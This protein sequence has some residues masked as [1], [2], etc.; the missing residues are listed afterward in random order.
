VS[1]AGKDPNKRHRHDVGQVSHGP[2]SQE[3]LMRGI[4]YTLGACVIGTIVLL[5]YALSA[6]GGQIL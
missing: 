1:D 4:Q 6:K 2:R 3:A 5:I